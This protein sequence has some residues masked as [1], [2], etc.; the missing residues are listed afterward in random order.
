MINHTNLSKLSV[1]TAGALIYEIRKTS[2][3]HPLYC[4]YGFSGATGTSPGSL[5]AVR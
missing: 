3:G 4:N 1:V 2:L 5:V